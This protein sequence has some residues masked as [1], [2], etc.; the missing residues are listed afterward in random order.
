[1]LSLMTLFLAIFLTG[2]CILDIFL[3]DFKQFSKHLRIFHS[4]SIKFDTFFVLPFFFN[5]DL[6][7]ARLNSNQEA[8][9]YKKKKDRNIKAY[10]E[11]G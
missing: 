1:M 3:S 10:R 4:I 6:L 11:S 8:W 5:W 7:H 2:F 9:S